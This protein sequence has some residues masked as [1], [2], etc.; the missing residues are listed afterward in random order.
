MHGARIS[1]T[2][3]AFADDTDQVRA[4]L[5][6]HTESWVVPLINAIER[7]DL[8]TL[9]QL[10]KNNQPAANSIEKEPV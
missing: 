2:G 6:T 1:L 5:K 9:A 3:A 7:G 10:V 8:G 4:A